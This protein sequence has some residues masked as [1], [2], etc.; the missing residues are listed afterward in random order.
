ME[1]ETFTQSYE[2][3]VNN[4]WNT[5]EA[6]KD[7]V[8]GIDFS[9]KYWMKQCYRVWFFLSIIFVA[10]Y[11]FSN[12]NSLVYTV[13]SIKNGSVGEVKSGFQENLQYLGGSTNIIRGDLENS[14][15]SLAEKAIMA[16][17]RITDI[18]RFTSRERMTTPEEE[19]M[20]KIAK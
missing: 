14:Q 5:A 3:G 9:I 6:T 12:V 16:N 13:Y 1:T 20:K 4:P 8:A 10:V 17:Q 11:L 19:L 15:D 2:G 7:R 18:Q